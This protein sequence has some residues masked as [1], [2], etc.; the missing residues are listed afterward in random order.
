MLLA[1]VLLQVPDNHLF[2]SGKAFRVSS[3]VLTVEADGEIHSPEFH[4]QVAF[5]W[6]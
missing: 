1:N 2:Q 5:S 3:A 6:Q 4:R